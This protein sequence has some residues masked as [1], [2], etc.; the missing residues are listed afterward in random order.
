MGKG[1]SHPFPSLVTKELENMRHK[2]EKKLVNRDTHVKN[3][4]KVA[5]LEPKTLQIKEWLQTT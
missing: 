1:L 2:L 3:N 4:L 5:G